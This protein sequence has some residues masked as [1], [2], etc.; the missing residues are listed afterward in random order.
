MYC[1]NI[2]SYNKR[3]I[4]TNFKDLNNV[5]PQNYIS[6]SKYLK[7]TKRDKFKRICENRVNKAIE[8]IQLLSHLS[9]KSQYDYDTLYVKT[10]IEVIKLEISKLENAFKTNN[11]KIA[12]YE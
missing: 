4:S 10:M 12:N 7:E 1:E 9:N 6:P 2:D 5:L 8:K 11:R 3:N